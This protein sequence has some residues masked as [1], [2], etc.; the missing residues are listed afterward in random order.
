M[1]YGKSPTTHFDEGYSIL[2]TRRCNHNWRRRTL[3]VVTWLDIAT[4]FPVVTDCRR[5]LA[6]I[7]MKPASA[8]DVQ[9]FILK[10]SEQLTRQSNQAMLASEINQRTVRYAIS[11]CG[12]HYRSVE[13]VFTTLDS[14][15]VSVGCRDNYIAAALHLFIATYWD[16]NLW[17][18][19]TDSFGGCFD[20]AA[21]IQ[22][23]SMNSQGLIYRDVDVD[24]G[25]RAVVAPN[26]VPHAIFLYFRFPGRF[27]FIGS[28]FTAVDRA[29]INSKAEKAWE[30]VIPLLE[31]I[32]AL[33][34]ART[35]SL[36]ELTL[37]SVYGAAGNQLV[38][39]G[40]APSVS[41]AR[42]KAYTSWNDYTNWEQQGPQ[43]IDM[44]RRQLQ[45]HLSRE[46]LTAFPSVGNFPGIEGGCRLFDITTLVQLKLYGAITKQQVI[47]FAA[48]A[49]KAATMTQV[50]YPYFVV[51]YVSQP[52]LA[53]LTETELPE[54]TAVVFIEPLTHMLEHFGVSPLL[55]E[56]QA[57]GGVKE[58][59]T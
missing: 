34:L 11:R 26:V 46:L 37:R 5:K 22:E 27:D 53:D 15:S 31:C 23:F 54:N 29:L 39:N 32:V 55:H 20:R 10:A 24:V 4:V 3:A 14:V 16:R 49:H 51:I 45:R 19:E 18:R 6:A 59:A 41:V 35:T 33:L 8:D 42:L 40:R 48:K 1:N 57:K 12:C 7:R 52:C 43:A 21:T 47:E 58:E 44:Q 30:T 36:T 9:A 50:T 2:S 17:C 25:V 56:V 38:I 28:L 13:Q